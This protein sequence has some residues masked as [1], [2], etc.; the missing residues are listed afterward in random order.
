MEAPVEGEVVEW[1]EGMEA[2]G[3]VPVQALEVSVRTHAQNNP[4]RDA[5]PHHFV[6]QGTP[7]LLPQTPPPLPNG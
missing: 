2:A 6:N 5:H 7:P 1:Q 3:P 4:S